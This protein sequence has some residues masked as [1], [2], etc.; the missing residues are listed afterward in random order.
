MRYL[1]RVLVYMLPCAA[2]SAVL[3]LYTLL[4]RVLT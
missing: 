4:Y 3:L 2:A 1:K